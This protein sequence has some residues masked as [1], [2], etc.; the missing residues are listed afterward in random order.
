MIYNMEN[1]QE[2]VE[3]VKQSDD[4]SREHNFKARRKTTRDLNLA[5]RVPRLLDLPS[6]PIACLN[7]NNCYKLL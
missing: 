5:F 3:D 1:T 4:E 6:P 7:K 2:Q